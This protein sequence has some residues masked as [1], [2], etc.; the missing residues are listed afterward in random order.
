MK[1]FF[2]ILIIIISL[3][4]QAQNDHLKYAA[5]NVVTNGIIAGIGS[6]IHKKEHETFF[7][8]FGQGAWKGATGGMLNYY[9]MRLV[10]VSANNDNLNWI[11]PGRII[12]ALGSSITYNAVKND[13]IWSSFAMNVFF[14]N[15]Q[16]DG[17]VHLRVDP[18][19]LGYATVLTFRKD[20]RF[21]FKNS[22][23]TGST[24]FEQKADTSTLYT[25][26][27]GHFGTAFGNTTYY[28]PAK[29]YFY[30]YSDKGETFIN[31]GNSYFVLTS[32]RT[33]KNITINTICHELIH[34]FQYEDYYYLNGLGVS[35]LKI[36]KYLYI[37]L[38]FG[39]LYFLNNLGGYDNNYFEKEADLFG[40]AN[41]Y[42]NNKSFN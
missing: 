4:C 37:N 42:K 34:N 33:I 22:L 41:Y 32:T 40:K 14:M 29:E 24:L 16:Y 19:S 17:K 26:E 35:S 39:G 30:N 6:G 8:A 28:K 1:R 21:D 25:I 2:A 5:F 3:N 13:K 11:W 7:H 18:L 23:L 9:G 38:N 10:E 27:S 31:D 15:V 36:N 20:M 12:N